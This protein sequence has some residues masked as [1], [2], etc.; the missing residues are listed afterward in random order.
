MINVSQ[1]I[2]FVETRAA[3]VSGQRAPF[4]PRVMTDSQQEHYFAFKSQEIREQE[5][6]IDRKE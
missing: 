4:E 3:K 2:E 1:T 5:D 6:S